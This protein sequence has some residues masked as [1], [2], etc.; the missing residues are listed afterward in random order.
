MEHQGHDM[1]RC[2]VIIDW[3]QAPP[4]S[5]PYLPSFGGGD[6]TEEGLDLRHVPVIPQIWRAPSLGLGVLPEFS[7]WR[8]EAGGG[9]RGRPQISIFVREGKEEPKA[10]PRVWNSTSN[11]A[12]GLKFQ[13]LPPHF[14]KCRPLKH[15]KIKQ[16]MTDASA[17][18]RTI[19]T[20]N[21]V[22]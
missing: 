3:R 10:V 5:K 21:G 15:W 6:G 14:G 20:N 4:N 16:N 9:S 17:D 12:E 19:H 2:V 22:T 11:V 8:L 1:M 7:G 18:R 13:T